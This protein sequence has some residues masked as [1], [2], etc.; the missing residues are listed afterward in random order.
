MTRRRAGYQGDDVVTENKIPVVRTIEKKIEL[1]FGMAG[2]DSFEV[3]IAEP[4][5]S[6]EFSM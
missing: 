6:F 3:L 5:D 1:V 2:C 4:P